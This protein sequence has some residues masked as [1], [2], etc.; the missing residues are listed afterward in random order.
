MDIGTAPLPP[1]VHPPL[2]LIAGSCS[3]RTEFEY[4]FKRRHDLASTIPRRG[5]AL[6]EASPM[7]YRL[8]KLVQVYG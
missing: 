1:Q 6:A 4:R 7:P 3:Y 2:V 8:R 5:Y